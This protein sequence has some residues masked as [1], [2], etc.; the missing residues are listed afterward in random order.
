MVTIL[1]Q[2]KYSFLF[3]SDNSENG[4]G[5]RMETETAPRQHHTTKFPSSALKERST[6]PPRGPLPH[7]CSK[8][9]LHKVL[10]A[11]ENLAFTK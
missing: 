2:N 10:H 11:S 9:Q 1:E 6:W 7:P 5:E 3:D 4:M 8:M